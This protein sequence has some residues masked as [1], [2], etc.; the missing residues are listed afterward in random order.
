[1]NLHLR[2]NPVAYCQFMRIRTGIKILLIVPSDLS[3][4]KPS[5]HITNYKFLFS[6]LCLYF[7][8][9]SIMAYYLSLML[10]FSKSTILWLFPRG[11]SIFLLDFF[12]TYLF[13]LGWC[14]GLNIVE[15]SLKKKP[16]IV[17]F[18]LYKRGAV[19]GTQDRLKTLKQNSD[20]M[21][22]SLFT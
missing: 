21:I 12:H 2:V 17:H 5:Q 10:N 3:L 8:Q 16:T 19:K 14:G 9:K 6:F 15:F 13:Q 1:M 7:H 11:L 22:Q 4:V 18:N 20:L